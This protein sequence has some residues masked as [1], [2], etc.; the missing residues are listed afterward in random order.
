MICGNT[1]YTAFGKRGFLAVEKVVLGFGDLE[2]RFVLRGSFL[3]AFGGSRV[4]RPFEY[5]HRIW[6]TRV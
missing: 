6:A 4:S 1:R 2:R 3:R 5:V